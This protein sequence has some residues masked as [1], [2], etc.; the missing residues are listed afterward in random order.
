MGEQRPPEEVVRHYRDETDEGQRLA[1]GLRQLELL[2]TREIVRRLEEELRASG[3]RVWEVL[4]VEGLAGWLEH[5]AGRWPDPAAWEAILWS[6]RAVEAEP[7]LRGL[8]A[9]LLSVAARPAEAGPP[10]SGPLDSDDFLV[11]L[12]GQHELP[13]PKHLYASLVKWG[14]RA[15]SCGVG[16]TRA[17][18]AGCR[19]A[20]SGCR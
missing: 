5:L 12:P 20:A 18:C 17:R 7:S 3:L 10:G 15:Q 11:V 4:G 9:H 8:S 1:R 2:R 6:A 19:W 14:G 16:W 13:S